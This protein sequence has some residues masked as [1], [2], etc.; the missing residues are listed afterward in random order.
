MVK[1]VVVVPEDTD[2]LKLAGYLA[3]LHA[4][5]MMTIARDLG[6]QG[7]TEPQ[8]I[9][10]LSPLAETVTAADKIAESILSGEFDVEVSEETTITFDGEA[11]SFASPSARIVIDRGNLPE[12][13]RTL[14]SPGSPVRKLGWVRR[15]LKRY[16]RELGIAN[17]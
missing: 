2:P 11:L 1:P 15:F 17:P 13:W 3:A 4:Y 5:M 14:L 8:I 16:G 7:A 9:A 12:I 6:Q 10:L